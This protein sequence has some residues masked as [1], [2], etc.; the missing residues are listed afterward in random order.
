MLHQKG[1]EEPP[2]INVHGWHC[3]CL[4]HFVD[5]IRFEHTLINYQSRRSIGDCAGS[6]G[7]DGIG[8]TENV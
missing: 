8:W 3:H 1:G 4:V 7:T 5:E 2:V 6:A